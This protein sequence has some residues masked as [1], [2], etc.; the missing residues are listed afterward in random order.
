MAVEREMVE[1][2][3]ETMALKRRM[4]AESDTSLSIFFNILVKR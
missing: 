2:R 3:E 1:V 4:R